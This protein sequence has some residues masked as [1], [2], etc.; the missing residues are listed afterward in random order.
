MRNVFSENP[1]F[2]TTTIVALFGI[3]ASHRLLLYREKKRNFDDCA[4]EFTRVFN[5]AFVDIHDGRYG[6]GTHSANQEIF[7][8]QCITYRN[9]RERLSGGNRSKYDEAWEK[10]CHDYQNLGGMNVLTRITRVDLEK[11]IKIL[12]KFAKQGMFRDLFSKKGKNV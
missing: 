11:D 1:I 2:A 6:I 7:R 9:F 8:T 4:D 12:L 5:Q 3:L 10:Y